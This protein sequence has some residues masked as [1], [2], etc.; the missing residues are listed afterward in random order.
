MTLYPAIEPLV[1]R[2]ESAL[3]SQEPA[4]ICE[5]VKRALTDELRGVQNLVPDHFLEPVP[6]RYARRLVHKDPRGRFSMVMMVWGA[7]QGTPLHDHAGHWCV[8]CVYRGR[9]RV[10]SFEAEESDSD[11]RVRFAQRSEVLAG[12]GAAGAL[13]P[14]HEY[15]TIDNP[16]DATAVTLHVYAGEITWCHVFEPTDQVG[17]YTRQRRDLSYVT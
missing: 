5:Q 9:I 13:I 2:L 16:N 4:A 12:L 6:D 15:H 3:S 1:Q 14:P 11:G 17:W 7:G 10:R 8:E